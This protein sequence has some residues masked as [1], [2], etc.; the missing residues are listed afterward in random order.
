MLL[1]VF[2]RSKWQLISVSLLVLSPSLSS[3][4]KRYNT[5]EPRERLLQTPSKLNEE[6]LEILR[7]LVVTHPDATLRELRQYLFNETDILMSISSIDRI[8]RTKLGFTSKKSLYPEQK[9]SDRVQEARFKYWQL[10]KDLPIADLIFLDESGVNLSFVR[11]MAR[12]LKGK[13][14]YGAKPAKSSNN[15]SVISAVSVKEVL[16]QWSALGSVDGVCFEAFIAC[17]LV[18]KLWKGAIVIMDN[19]SIHKGSEVERLIKEAGATLIYLP[20][21]SP[22]FSPIEN[23]WSK[24]KSILRTLGA[25]TYPDLMEALEAAFDEITQEDLKGWFN[26]CGYSS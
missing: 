6:N 13:R 4:K 11:K 26:H 7:Q 9:A 15:V 18:P 12:A 1:V 20:P 22:D 19:C 17:M 23:A 21:Y 2:H 24:L 5:I 3:V 16:V 14:A 10:L 25:R 8:V